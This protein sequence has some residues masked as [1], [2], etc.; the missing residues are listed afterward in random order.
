M[1][2]HKNA[3]QKRRA[4]NGPIGP[5]DNLSA[6]L[7]KPT[8]LHKQIMSMDG[9]R[10]LLARGLP[11][12]VRTPL[13]VARLLLQPEHSFKR[14]CGEPL[15]ALMLTVMFAVSP[16]ADAGMTHDR[17]RHSARKK[18]AVDGRCACSPSSPAAVTSS[19]DSCRHPHDDYRGRGRR[20]NAADSVGFADS[21]RTRLAAGSAPLRMT[22]APVATAGIVA[23]VVANPT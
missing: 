7:D 9:T 13:S 23:P 11:V 22:I 17:R 6:N 3:R 8:N 4:Q 16:V 15:S 18:N 14:R 12:S 10:N 5:D 1:M 21:C 19:A 20:P 2:G